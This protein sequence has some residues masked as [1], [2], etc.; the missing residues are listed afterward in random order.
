MAAFQATNVLTGT[1]EGPKYNATGVTDEIWSVAL[2]NTLAINDTISGPVIPAGVYLSNFVIDVDQLDSNGSP[3]I[4]LKAG[5]VGTTAAFIATGNTIAR[6]GG[7]QAANVAG[8]IGFTA[9][10][11]QTTLVTITAAGATKV[12]GTMRIKV[13][14]TASP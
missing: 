7:I 1:A 5:V 2:P 11:N 10:T 8:T 12:A 3:L 13:S 6:T 4:A 14:Y 9:T